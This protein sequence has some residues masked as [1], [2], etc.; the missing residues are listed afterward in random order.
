MLLASD[1]S[2][3]PH[4]DPC[5]SGC[6]PSID[7]PSHTKTCKS[8]QMQVLQ[9][10]FDAPLLSMWLFQD[11]VVSGEYNMPVVLGE[12]WLCCQVQYH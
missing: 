6:M 2:D 12:I 5:S 11:A 4:A 1:A 10:P 9:Q 3:E 8:K 7:T